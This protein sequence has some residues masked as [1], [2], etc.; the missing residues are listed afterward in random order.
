MAPDIQT[1][2]AIRPAIGVF[3]IMTDAARTAADARLQ[4]TPEQNTLLWFELTDLCESFLLAGLRREV[5]RNGNLEAAYRDWQRRQ[6]G[7]HDRTLIRM[8]QRLADIPVADHASDRT[9]G[10]PMLPDRRRNVDAP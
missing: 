8:L 10:T 5:G 3:T 9:G 7:E 2:R 4:S 6:M 1:S